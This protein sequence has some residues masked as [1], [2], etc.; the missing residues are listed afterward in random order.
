MFILF[1]I[2]ISKFEI[3]IGNIFYYKVK[4]VLK[5]RNVVLIKS[6]Y[7]NINFLIFSY[8]R[9]GQTVDREQSK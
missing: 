4:V 2:N 8:T 1:G 6:D 9:G 3:I 7:K 5:K